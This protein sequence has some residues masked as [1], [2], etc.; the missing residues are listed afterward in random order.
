MF[1]FRAGLGVNESGSRSYCVVTSRRG[2]C[3]L[4]RGQPRQILAAGSTTESSARFQELLSSAMLQTDKTI[5][6]YQAIDSILGVLS[7][8]AANMGQY[9]VGWVG[10]LIRSPVVEVLKEWWGSGTRPGS[11]RFRRGAARAP[12]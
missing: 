10:P 5:D 1:G 11:A 7:W 4:A 9:C 12:A 8:P 2:S 3:R 6:Y